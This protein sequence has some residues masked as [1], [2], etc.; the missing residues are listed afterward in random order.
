MYKY[1]PLCATSE[2]FP[3]F[4]YQPAS[5]AGFENLFLEDFS[6]QTELSSLGLK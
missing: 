4:H 6:E 5:H 2:E 3:N 1:T